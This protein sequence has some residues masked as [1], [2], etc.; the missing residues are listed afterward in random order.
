MITGDEW[1]KIQ[2]LRIKN[3]Y[4]QWGWAKFTHFFRCDNPSCPAQYFQ[5]DSNKYCGMTDADYDYAEQACACEYC[6]QLMT[7]LQEITE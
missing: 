5:S 1:D 2:I 3:I 7:E 4:G 6:G